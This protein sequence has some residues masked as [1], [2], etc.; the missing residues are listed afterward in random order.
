M[1]SAS[2]SDAEGA[3]EKFDGHNKSVA[4]WFTA[5]EKIAAIPSVSPLEFVHRS[6]PNKKLP[7][8]IEFKLL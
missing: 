1:A 3:L 8:Q 7:N 6:E 2:F 5:Y 4:E